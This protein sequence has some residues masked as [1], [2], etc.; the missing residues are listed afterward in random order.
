MKN[1]KPV[2][3]SD[4]KKSLGKLP[5][6]KNARIREAVKQK[7]KSMGFMKKRWKELNLKCKKRLEIMLKKK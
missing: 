5:I 1:L 3:K 6:E 4:K 7:K 2:P